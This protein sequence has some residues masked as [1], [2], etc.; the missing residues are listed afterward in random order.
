MKK[1][2][3]Y[4]PPNNEV[5]ATTLVGAAPPN[6]PPLGIEVNPPNSDYLS[7]VADVEVGQLPKLPLEVAGCERLPNKP[8]L[9]T[10]DA[11][12]PPLVDLGGSLLFFTGESTPLEVVSFE[13]L[14]CVLSKR[15]CC[16]IALEIIG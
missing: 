16:A 10:A 7:L 1:D 3:S 11:V 6:N 15:G 12:V 4:G 2:F 9:L 13:P 14:V 8:P 5:E